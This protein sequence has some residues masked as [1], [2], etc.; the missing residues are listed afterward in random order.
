MEAI[1]RLSTPAVLMPM[2]PIYDGQLGVVGNAPVTYHSVVLIS[3]V[4]T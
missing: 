2:M 4:F 3:S 1:L